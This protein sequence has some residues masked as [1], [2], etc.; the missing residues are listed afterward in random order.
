MQ[1]LDLTLTPD[2]IGHV[3]EV[4]HIELGFPHDFLLGGF[5]RN[6]LWRDLTTGSTITALQAPRR[7]DEPTEATGSL[8]AGQHHVTTNGRGHP[9]RS[10][11]QSG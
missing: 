7:L 10:A 11:S 8:A 9:C 6:F 1:S 5:V 4:S 3:N 2:Q